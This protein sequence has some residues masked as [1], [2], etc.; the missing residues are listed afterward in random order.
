MEEEL[1]CY[2]EVEDI[3]FNALAVTGDLAYVGEVFID[4]RTAGDEVIKEV[5]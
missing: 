2:C 5:E 4:Q 3:D 1:K